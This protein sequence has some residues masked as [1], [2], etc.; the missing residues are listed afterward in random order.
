MRRGSEGRGQPHPN[1]SAKNR[2]GPCDCID[3]VDEILNLYVVDDYVY[4]YLPSRRA[5]GPFDRYQMANTTPNY[6]A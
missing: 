3:A 5:S 1:I 6:A 4:G 2:P